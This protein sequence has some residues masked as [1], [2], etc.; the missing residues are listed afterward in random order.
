[1]AKEGEKLEGNTEKLIRLEVWIERLK[2]LMLIGLALCVLGGIL[3]FF[4]DPIVAFVR[5]LLGGQQYSPILLQL[6]G[7]VFAFGVSFC[8]I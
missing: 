6:S 1:M 8:C 7:Y 4:V 5:G 2:S 3:G